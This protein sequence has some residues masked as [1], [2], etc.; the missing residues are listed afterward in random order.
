MKET[1][2]GQGW[3][4]S[5]EAAEGVISSVVVV[6]VA[7]KQVRRWKWSGGNGRMGLKERNGE[8]VVMV[9]EVRNSAVPMPYSASFELDIG[10]VLCLPS[11]PSPSPPYDCYR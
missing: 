1:H 10:V 3:S 4:W 8:L 9:R 7:E 11:P 6:A 2:S 5:E